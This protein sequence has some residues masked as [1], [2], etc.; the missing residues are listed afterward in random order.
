MLSFLAQPKRKLF[1]KL[2]LILVLFSFLGTSLG[3]NYAHAALALPEPTQL[4]GLSPSYS[5]PILKGLKLN[6]ANPLQIEFII[7]SA[8]QDTVSKEEASKLIRYF[9]AGLTIPE[10]DLW[11]N[12]SV[13][14]KDHIINESAAAT[15]VGRDMLAQDYVLKQLVSSLTYPESEVGKSYW[16]KAYQAAAK[17]FGTTDIK[18]DTFNKIWI[19][20]DKAEVYEYKNTAVVNQ[21]TLKAMLEQDFLA[22]QKGTKDEVRQFVKQIGETSPSAGWRERGM[23]DEKAGQINKV[24]SDVM[25]EV[26]VPKITEDINSGKN[27]ATLRQIY[28]SLILAKWFKEKFKESFYKHYINQ[29]KIKGI[30]IHDPTAKEQIYNLYTQAFKKGIYDYIKKEVVPVEPVMP[31]AGLKSSNGLNRPNSFKTVRRRYFSG[32]INFLIGVVSSVVPSATFDATQR[33]GKFNAVGTLLTN[34]VANDNSIGVAGSPAGMETD[35]R[36]M[37]DE[38]R[39]ED[40]VGREDVGRGTKGASA[41]PASASPVKDFDVFLGVILNDESLQHAHPAIYQK[42][43]ARGSANKVR[44]DIVKELD[45]IR[46][47]L[48]DAQGPVD[49]EALHQYLLAKAQDFR[50]KG[51]YK[52]EAIAYFHALRVLAGPISSLT[53]L[54]VHDIASKDHYSSVQKSLLDAISRSYRA[55]PQHEIDYFNTLWKSRNTSIRELWQWVQ[56]NTIVGCLDYVVDSGDGF[57]A[58]RSRWDKIDQSCKFFEALESHRT[59]ESNDHWYDYLNSRRAAGEEPLD[60]EL[61]EAMQEGYDRIEQGGKDETIKKIIFLSNLTMDYPKILLGND[62]ASV[63]PVLWPFYKMLPIE[64]EDTELLLVLAEEH[65]DYRTLGL[66]DSRGPEAFVKKLSVEPPQQEEERLPEPAYDAPAAAKLKEAFNGNGADVAGKLEALYQSGDLARA[67]SYLALLDRP[68]TKGVTILQHCV[69]VV[70][71]MA[72]VDEGDFA[73][74][75]ALRKGKPY[76]PESHFRS[77]S[78]ALRQARDYIAGLYDEQTANRLIYLAAFMHD[79]GDIFNYGDHTTRGAAM[80]E[81]VLAILGINDRRIANWFRFIIRYHSEFGG[82]NIA[83]KTNAPILEALKQEFDLQSAGEAAEADMLLKLTVAINSADVMSYQDGVF[84]TADDAELMAGYLSLEKL[85]RFDAAEF[86]RLRYACNE[87]GVVNEFRLDV[88]GKTM[89]LLQKRYRGF[90]PFLGSAEM[91]H[92]K[93]IFANL[94]ETDVGRL[95]RLSYIISRAPGQNAEARTFDFTASRRLAPLSFQP[96]HERLAEVDF[97]RL[98]ELPIHDAVR[99]L[100]E[101]GLITYLSGDEGTVYYNNKYLTHIIRYFSAAAINTLAYY[102]SRGVGTLTDDHLGNFLVMYNLSEI[103]RLRMFA[104]HWPVIRLLYALLNGVVRGEKMFNLKSMAPKFENRNEEPKDLLLSIARDLITEDQQYSRQH[105]E[106][107]DALREIDQAGHMQI[108]IDWLSRANTV[109]LN[110]TARW[111]DFGAAGFVK[112][113]YTL[114]LLWSR[115]TAQEKDRPYLFAGKYIGKLEREKVAIVAKTVPDIAGQFQKL[116]AGDISEAKFISE[117]FGLT[118]EGYYEDAEKTIVTL[119]QAAAAASPMEMKTERRGMKDEGRKDDIAAERGTKAGSPAIPGNAPR[120]PV[121]FIASSDPYTVKGE[122][123]VP[124]DAKNGKAKICILSMGMFIALWSNIWIEN[125]RMMQITNSAQTNGL[126]HSI[127]YDAVRDVLTVEARNLSNTRQLEAYLISAASPAEGKTKVGLV[128]SAVPQR[129]RRHVIK[130]KDGVDPEYLAGINAKEKKTIVIYGGLGSLGER[131]L[132]PGIRELNDTFNVDFIAV[133]TKDPS[134]EADRRFIKKRKQVLKDAGLPVSAYFSI[135][136]FGKALDKARGTIR[137]KGRDI[138]VDGVITAVPTKYHLKYAQTWVRR[139]IPVWMEKPITMVDEIPGLKRLNTQHPGKIFAVDFFMDS[140]ALMS[141]LKDKD[142]LGGIGKIKRIDG[143]CVE[144]WGVEREPRK[145]LLDPAIS[146]GG[147]MIDTAVHPLAMIESVLTTK[148][149]TLGQAEV[150]DCRLARYVNNPA[151]KIVPSQTETYGWIKG[152]VGDIEFYVDSGKGV[153][154]V[155]YGITI[156]G[157][158]G[159]VEVFVGTETLDPY[160]KVTHKDSSVDMYRFSK[161]SLGYKRTF[162]D[163]ML[164]LHGSKKHDGVGLD[165]RMSAAMHSLEVVGKAY[166]K[167]EGIGTYLLG[168][169][170]T[171]PTEVQGMPFKGLRPKGKALWGNGEVLTKSKSTVGSSPASAERPRDEVRQFTKQIGETSPSTGWRGRGMRDEGRNDDTAV[172]RGTSAASPLGRG[173]R[174]KGS[175]SPLWWNLRKLKSYKLETRIEAANQLA[176]RGGRD[177]MDILFA[178][179]RGERS[180]GVRSAIIRALKHN[181]NYAGPMLVDALR[182]SDPDIRVSAVM[183]LGEM[184][185]SSYE[186]A[187]YA[188]FSNTNPVAVYNALVN[189]NGKM[190]RSV[191]DIYAELKRQDGDFSLLPEAIRLAAAGYGFK[192]EVKREVVIDKVGHEGVVDE[193]IKSFPTDN[194]DNVQEY[195][196]QGYRITDISADGSYIGS[197]SAVGYYFYLEKRGLVYNSPTEKV[198]RTLVPVKIGSSPTST[199]MKTAGSPVSLPIGLLD[200]T[201]EIFSQADTEKLDTIKD[202]FNSFADGLLRSYKPE[203]DEADLARIKQLTEHTVEFLKAMKSRDTRIRGVKEKLLPIIGLLHDIG[204]VITY[205]GHEESGV[206]VLTDHNIIGQLVDSGYISK[207]EGALVETAVRYHTFVGL[208]WI[209]EKGYVTWKE[210][211]EDSAVAAWR[212]GNDLSTLLELI[213]KMG[214]FDLLAYKNSLQSSREKGYIDLA[215]T[216]AAAVSRGGNLEENLA[217]LDREKSPERVEHLISWRDN[218]MDSSRRVGYMGEWGKAAEA[219][220]AQEAFMKILETV[221]GHRDIQSFINEALGKEANIERFGVIYPALAWSDAAAAGSEED[222]AKTLYFWQEIT[223]GHSVNPGA[224]KFLALLLLAGRIFPG[225]SSIVT[226]GKD[227]VEIAKLIGKPGFSRYLYALNQAMAS[228]T[229]IKV[230]EDKI[231]LLGEGG[232]PLGSFMQFDQSKGTI[233]FFAE[234]ADA[235]SPAFLDD[236]AKAAGRKASLS[237]PL[238]Q[239]KVVDIPSRQN[240]NWVWFPMTEPERADFKAGRKVLHIYGENSNEALAVVRY[241]LPGEPDPRAQKIKVEAPK[242]SVTGQ[243]PW[244]VNIQKTG[245]VAKIIVSYDP[246]GER[247]LVKGKNFDLRGIPK[248]FHMMLATPREG[249]AGLVAK[250]LAGV[251]LASRDAGT[252]SH[253]YAAGKIITP[254][255]GYRVP[256]EKGRPILSQVKSIAAALN[257]VPEEQIEVDFISRDKENSIRGFRVTILPPAGGIAGNGAAGS[258][259]NANP[260]SS[261]SVN[262]DAPGGIKMSNIPVISS[263]ASQKIEFAAIGPDFFDRL[264]FRIV[265]MRHIASLA[266]FASIP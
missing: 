110:Y 116:C 232:A 178:A 26:V 46:T 185:D 164:F 214:I 155:Y 255:S 57:W 137:I 262:A 83:E 42:I 107:Y 126:T 227:N 34:E 143:R 264:T 133:D 197:G 56:R 53:E 201:I 157:D 70:R 32:G 180:S 194:N 64:K 111:V 225:H 120:I 36:G 31:V 217:A 117:T 134:R 163:F 202:S 65:R 22:L 125:G 205:V 63:R 49:L 165:T 79:I 50:D 39:G 153:G 113:I 172:G 72:A 7:D 170:P 154:R 231:T 240:S 236:N 124:E 119:T 24:A 183:V 260:R 37:R 6:P 17:A 9:L 188:A 261:S 174:E 249:D 204:K 147:L 112:F 19:A 242:A 258:G 151:D 140:D 55:I 192:V 73:G 28:Y 141:V 25:R 94:S 93:E 250:G 47:Q 81:P 82:M 221:T 206:K 212:A 88:L 21:A 251:R 216:V 80:I 253:D 266:Q 16:Q 38:G 13:Y 61:L 184:R 118:A 23:K 168:N 78:R 45:L 60:R 5:F 103:H 149:M 211:F 77:L 86:R 132:G 90:A 18:L 254:R 104:K 218:N 241:F 162:L 135:G 187:V 190:R 114:A 87:R 54:M 27:F 223:A 122:I 95:L 89:R 146:G 238:E 51:D 52:S 41:S 92:S 48:G 175:A 263:A 58:G 115:R 169:D 128:S 121:T 85:V 74:F 131:F 234:P 139:N 257:N 244:E 161:G 69:Q 228:L 182:G 176:L 67:I 208:N 150:E 30:D 247:I 195:L 148:G 138:K 222:F 142:I 199:A 136:N 99:Y 44:G 177:I 97:E 66:G 259:T 243:N 156:T 237:S 246:S 220:Q 35:G 215:E 167:S 226:L 75:S 213:A 2:T 40:T 1:S 196:D 191:E 3:T 152:R 101:M 193:Q 207:D 200:K 219:V 158:K 245:L 252:Y 15:D 230:S 84:F 76:I 186:D 33:M 20:P 235:S 43:K 109:R 203:P 209:G 129:I 106:V 11:V 100:T 98:A 189:I 173:K 256:V 14:E 159:S 239:G 144:T 71:W 171:V 181:N 59:G 62:D 130:K 233:T 127:A 224:V 166:K 91:G 198:T 29:K 102:A 12:L 68:K 265:S 210:F 160:I 179:Y 105:Q 248:P 96:L 4:L 229:G 145:W 108:L 8:N 123:I 10:D